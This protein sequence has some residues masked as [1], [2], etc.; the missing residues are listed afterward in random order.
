MGWTMPC[1]SRAALASP[2]QARQH[3]TVNLARNLSE[4]LAPLVD[5]VFPPRCPLCSTGLAA[6]Q[7]LCGACWSELV[8]P[9]RPACARCQRP[10]GEGRVPDGAICAP[11]MAAPPRHDGIAAGTLYNDT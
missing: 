8:I 4:T 6:Q 1:A 11:C 9:G 7:G 2:A 10:F 5:L 3:C